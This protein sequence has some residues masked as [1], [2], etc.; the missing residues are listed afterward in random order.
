MRSPS[1]RVNPNDVIPWRDLAARTG[2]SAPCP[3]NSSF[4]TFI[5]GANYLPGVIC[6]R[7]TLHHAGNRCPVDLLYDDRTPAYNLST[8][9]YALLSRVY[10]AN[11]LIP[12]SSLMAKHPVGAMEMSYSLQ[13]E[14]PYGRRLYHRGVEH[15]ATHSKLW[16]WAL[17]RSRV[18]V[19]DA[20]MV[21][22]GALDWLMSLDFSQQ[23]AAIDV[24]SRKSETARFNSGLMVIRPAVEYARNLT[25]LAVAARQPPGAADHVE[26]P[27]A[28]E[29]NFGDQS[30]LNW[31]FRHS[32][33]ALPPSLVSVGTHPK[34][35]DI[36]WLRTKGPAVL[37]WLGEPKP[38]KAKGL[39][40][41]ATANGFLADWATGWKR[42]APSFWWNLCGE[43]LEGV[44]RRW[45]GGPHDPEVWNVADT[46]R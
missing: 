14:L 17:P 4:A 37:H 6:L 35:K 31:Y 27:K 28:S 21:V 2:T 23:M 18:V 39:R 26:V 43:H 24:S 16:L 25:H 44:P 1:L 40:V 34:S 33:L 22:V 29:K 30:L 11:R 8:E 20:D 38:W 3:P 9:A 46:K 42:S 45:L 15:L 12:L 19:L 41:N 5:S 13:K 10:G 32:W 7:R 36:N